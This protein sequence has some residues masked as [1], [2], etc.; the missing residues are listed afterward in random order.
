MVMKWVV[1]LAEMD[2]SQ[3]VRLVMVM[4]VLGVR[5]CL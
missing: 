4:S 3:Q 2:R 1:K 5:N